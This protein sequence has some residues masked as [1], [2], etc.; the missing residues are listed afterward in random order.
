VK[1][2]FLCWLALSLVVMA[3]VCIVVRVSEPGLSVAVMGTWIGVTLLPALSAFWLGLA[4]LLLGGGAGAGFRTPLP[5]YLATLPVSTGTLASQRLIAVLLIWIL[6]WLPLW[7]MLALGQYD[8]LV[9]RVPIDQ[10]IRQTAVSMAGWMALSAHTAVGALPLVLRGRLAGFPA[11]FLASMVCWT[12]PLLLYLGMKEGGGGI[13]SYAIA[14]AWLAAKI[15]VAAWALGRSTLAGQITRRFVCGTFGVWLALAAVLIWGLP[16][17]Q[18]G[19]LWRV[20]PILLFLPLARPALCPLA[21]DA[22]RQR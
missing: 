19:G 1:R 11:V 4:G 10:A 12:G 8:R 17:W 9:T 7:L 16:T 2:L 13:S 6:V 18:D 5:H 22:N 3:A 14:L 15:G 21:L 20:V